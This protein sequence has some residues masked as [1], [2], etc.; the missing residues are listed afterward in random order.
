MRTDCSAQLGSLVIALPS[1]HEG[2]Q[3]TVEHAGQQQTFDWSLNKLPDEP[4]L[5][6]GAFYSDCRHE[7]HEVTAGA[8]I[9][10]TYNLMAVKPT[11][12]V[13]KV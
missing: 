9:T 11:L 10:V 13:L 6:W 12:P 5:Q 8:R 2:G 3:L 4:I 1:V 7:V